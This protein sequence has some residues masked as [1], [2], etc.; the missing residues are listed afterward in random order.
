M[1]RR[2]VAVTLGRLRSCLAS[3]G[4]EF[5]LV[6]RGPTAF[7][8]TTR[9]ATRLRKTH[10]VIMVTCITTTSHPNTRQLTSFSPTAST[11]FVQTAH[12]LQTISHLRNSHTTPQFT[13]ATPSAQTAT[14]QS[15]KRFSKTESAPAASAS[16]SAHD[17]QPRPRAS[18]SRTYNEHVSN[19]RRETKWQMEL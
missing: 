17:D 13:P 9:R 5:A 2:R 19:E 14:S 7:G 15:T 1:M 4:L 12:A 11:S 10:E 8:T 3:A 6:Q 18:N 16:T